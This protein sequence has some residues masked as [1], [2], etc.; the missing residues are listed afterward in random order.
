MIHAGLTHNLSC[1]LST[2][3]GINMSEW[4][5]LVGRLSKIR[6]RY[7][8]HFSGIGMKRLHYIDDY[9]RITSIMHGIMLNIVL[10]Q[11]ENSVCMHDLFYNGE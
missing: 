3:G 8:D 1:R 11:E 5:T 6:A 2:L 4:Q 9:L 7:V 10:S